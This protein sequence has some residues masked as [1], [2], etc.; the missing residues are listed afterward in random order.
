MR[1]PKRRPYREMMAE[2][3]QKWND[4]SELAK[5]INSHPDSPGAERRKAKKKPRV[6]WPRKIDA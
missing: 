2:Y 1:K 4:L 6:Y 3:M 5:E